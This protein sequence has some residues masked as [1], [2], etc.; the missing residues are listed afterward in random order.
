[1]S[2][3][4]KCQQMA[5][6]LLMSIVMVITGKELFKT[7]GVDTF[8]LVWFF[9]LVFCVSFWYQILQGSSSFLILI[10]FASGTESKLITWSSAC[11]RLPCNNHQNVLV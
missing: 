4:L 10:N 11:V 9:G 8:A 1:M 6:A 5:V 3:I 7:S 2:M